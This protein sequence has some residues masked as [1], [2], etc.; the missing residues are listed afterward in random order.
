M[1][2]KKTPKGRTVEKNMNPVFK[3]WVDNGKEGVKLQRGESYLKMQ[4]GE[5]GLP[6][7]SGGSERNCKG[8]AG[9]LAFCSGQGI[10][11]HGEVKLVEGVM[12]KKKTQVRV[13]M[14]VT[15]WNGGGVGGIG[16]CFEQP[17]GGGI[18]GFVP[19]PK[20]QGI[21]E[22]RGLVEKGGGLV[23]FKHPLAVLN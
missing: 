16:V 13:Q 17:R 9:V 19:K 5:G 14:L 23:N 10:W 7:T 15:Q 6:P 22:I 1:G 3:P 20:F 12:P 21:G 4:R 8:K 11:S 2:K 18:G